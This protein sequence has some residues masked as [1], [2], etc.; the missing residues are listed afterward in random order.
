[1][2][3]ARSGLHEQ[4]GCP[5]VGLCSVS[6]MLC[7]SKHICAKSCPYNRP[8]DGTSCCLSSR[9]STL[10]FLMKKSSQHKLVGE[11]ETGF[12]I[13][14]DDGK[15]RREGIGCLPRARVQVIKH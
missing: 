8:Q 7:F 14:R 11:K 10:E 3:Q 1:M 4:I 15:A 9:K 6:V 12:L 13:S 5:K 2:G